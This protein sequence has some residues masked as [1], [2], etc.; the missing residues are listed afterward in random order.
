MADVD[1]LH[2]APWQRLLTSPI[3]EKI[4]AG[5]DLVLGTAYPSFLVNLYLL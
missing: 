1:E 3:G 4:H 2:I 5:N